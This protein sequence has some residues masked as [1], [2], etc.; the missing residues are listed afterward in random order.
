MDLSRL[1]EKQKEAV[2]YI[3]KPLLVF[4]GA[5]SGKTRVIVNKIVY[6]ISEKKVSSKKILALTFTKKAAQEMKQRVLELLGNETKIKGMFVGT[7]HSFGAMF[8]R[9]E[10]DSIFLNRSFT[11]YD[12]TDKEALIKS[13][14]KE[15]NISNASVKSVSSVISKLKSS[16]ITPDQYKRV[17]KTSPQEEL[18]ATIYEMYDKK[19]KILEAVDFDDLLL[20][21]LEILQN[22]PKIKQKYRNRYSYLLIDEYQDTNKIQ[23]KLIKEL[24][25]GKICVVGD[26]D[27]S[28]YSWRGADIEN[29][30]EFKRDFQDARIIKLD[31]NYRSTQK[32]IDAAYGVVSNNNY[33]EEKEIHSNSGGGDDIIVYEAEDEEDEA[34]FVL[35]RINMLR[36]KG[37]KLND[38]AV[39]FRTNA[40]SRVFEEIFV[41]Y[42]VPYSLFG[43]YR[44]YD[45]VEIKELISY[46]SYFTENNDDLSILRIINSPKRGIGPKKI[47]IIK[48]I[49]HD[50]D[51]SVKYL[52]KCYAYSLGLQMFGRN[53]YIKLKAEDLDSL[54]FLK[55]FINIFYNSKISETKNLSDYLVRIIKKIQYEKHIEHTFKDKAEEKWEN[56]EQLIYVTKKY[57]FSNEG[58]I[59]FI[60]DVVLMTEFDDK[61][62]SDTVNMMT[63]HASKGLEFPIVFIVGSEEGTLPHFRSLT[64]GKQLEEERRLFYVG[65]TRAKAILYI[66]YSRYLKRNSIYTSPSRFISEI[67]ENLIQRYT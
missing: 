47:E 63:L 66:S 43:G 12:T 39:F 57:P 26:D 54:G 37:H 16:M 49:A 50:Y 28:I 34:L 2:T 29:I 13:L 38:V 7:F 65:M 32:I 6:L 3:D 17:L 18:M 27:Q 1:N 19:I 55:D 23:Y 42:N 59:S 11:I 61:V 46:I 45:R 14:I 40:R 36:D 41:E 5:G 51:M 9:K 33:R 60:E 35:A 30:L 22:D 25:S 48:C 20:K 10:A 58:I 15:L 31:T 62:S 64:S 8:L 52:L 56:V 53:D 4:A 21:P 67:P 44:F 24:S